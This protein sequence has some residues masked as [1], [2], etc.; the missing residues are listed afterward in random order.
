MCIVNVIRILGAFCIIVCVVQAIGV[1]GTRIH[2]CV[3]QVLGCQVY[4]CK[5]CFA[6]D[7]HMCVLKVRGV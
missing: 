1:S 5:V 7:M 3:V 6:N 2:I 4:V